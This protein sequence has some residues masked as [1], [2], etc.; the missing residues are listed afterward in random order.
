M[1]VMGYV[2][3]TDLMPLRKAFL[4]LVLGWACWVAPV[5]AADAPK[6]GVELLADRTAVVPGDSVELA[7]KFSIE[8]EWHIYWHNRGEGGMEPTFKWA[9]PA[10]YKVGTLRWPA[11]K[12]HVDQIGTHTFILEGEPVLLTTLSVPDNVKV[13][14]RAAIGL[15]VTWL[16]CKQKCIRGSKSLSLNLPV[17]SSHEEA[18]PANADVFKVARAALPVAQNKAKYM[19]RIAVRANVKEVQPG[20]P[21][22]VAVV[23]EPA[24]HHHINSNKPLNEF[25]IP[26]DLFH[27]RTEGLDISRPRFP[28]GEVKELKKLRMKLLVYTGATEIVLPIQ[29]DNVLEGKEVRVSGVVKYQA[30]D[31]RTGRCYPPIAV[32][33][34]LTLPVAQMQVAPVVEDASPTAEEEQNVPDT[35]AGV[36]E[37]PL[38]PI[39][40]VGESW[41]QRVQ[42]SMEG[43]GIVGYFVMALIGGFILNFMPCVLPVISIKVLSFVQQAKES[44][45]RVFLLGTT[46]AFGIFA[47]FLVL[48]SLIIGLEQQW[49]GLF[50]RPQVVIGLAMVVTAF[51]L[52]LFGVFAFFPPRVVNELGEKVQ[53]E[54]YLSAFGMGLLATVLGTACTAPFLSAVVAIATQRSASVGML[55]FAVAGFGMAFPYVLL[56]AQPAWLK[57]IPK[58]GP[59]MK[60]FEQVVGFVLLATVV[61]LLNPLVTQLGGGGLLITLVFLV[62]VAFAVWLYGKV[63][64]GDPLGR[65]VRY[66]GATAVLIVGGWWICFHW[67]TTIDDLIADAKAMR[68]GG[69]AVVEVKWTGDEIPWQPYTRARAMDTIRSGRIIFVDYTAD[70]CVNCKVN[71]KLVIDTAEVRG[72]MK[73]LGIVPFKADYTSPDPEIKEDLARFNRSGVPMYVV[74]PAHRW[75]NPIL[76][77]ELLTKSAVIKALE[78]AGPSEEPD[79]ER[80]MGVE[81]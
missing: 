15:E 33:W 37:E 12:R 53:Q 21:F 79:V 78:L 56:A 50:Q 67:V 31:D 20:R 24:D 6:V 49:G 8:E 23:V 63:Q 39:A 72:A 70:W 73:E 18:K 29:P 71:E 65:R 48:G 64:Y 60:T 41:L 54:G 13:G 2:R 62:T 57:F 22:E 25:L 28:K 10:D 32:K 38:E 3:G 81:G 76:L 27:D 80:V 47:S 43:W 46:F 55:I 69:A 14:G 11:P 58:A 35:A 45:L 16:A 5:L 61:W 26:T 74:Y 17:V 52:S 75:D 9:L 42:R 59:W 51:A 36:E 1:I 44:R 4:A 7:V 34:S 19:K 68:L 66:Y 77:D 40:P 30:C